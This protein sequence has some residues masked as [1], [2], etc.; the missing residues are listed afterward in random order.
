[1]ADQ[2]TSIENGLHMIEPNTTSLPLLVECTSAINTLEEFLRWKITV[3]RHVQ[4]NSIDR[5]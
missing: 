5:N 2:A 3:E 4:V 1:M